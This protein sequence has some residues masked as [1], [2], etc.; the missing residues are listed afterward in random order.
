MLLRIIQNGD[1]QTEDENKKIMDENL[2]QMI[3]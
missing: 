1:N 2:V 3:E